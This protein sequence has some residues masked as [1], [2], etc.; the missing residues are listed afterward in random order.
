MATNVIHLMNGME[1]WDMKLASGLNGTMPIH[2][3][4]WVGLCQLMEDWLA[5]IKEAVE[6]VGSTQ[7][8]E[9]RAEG[10]PHT[11]LDWL[12]NTRRGL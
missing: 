3:M 2:D 7:R 4:E 8:E 12:Q 10:L 5:S 6:Y 1:T 11:R 9:S